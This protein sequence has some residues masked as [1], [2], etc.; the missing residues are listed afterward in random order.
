MRSQVKKWGNSLAI[1]VPKIL[2]E[3]AGLFEGVSVE[4]QLNDDAII[5]RQGYNL[6]ELMSQVSSENIHGEI[7]TGNSVGRE[8]W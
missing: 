1:R 4:L 8:E 7:N 3:R 6:E 2:A 5:R